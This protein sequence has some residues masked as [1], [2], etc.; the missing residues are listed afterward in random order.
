MKILHTSDWHIG[1]TLY[2]KKRY[3]EFFEFLNWLIRT[4]EQEKIELLL[5]AGDIF[6]TS[7][8]GNQAQALY[9]QFLCQAAASCCRHIVIIAGNHD[10]PSFL[11]AP[12]QLLQSLN[13]YV[14]AAVSEQIEDELIV[15]N[16]P[17]DNIPELIVCAVPF[18][19]DRDVR[20]VEAGE[21]IDD[22][23]LKLIEG[24]KKHYAKL[25]HLA[26]KKQDELYHVSNK[27]IPIIAMGHLFTAGGKT[28]DGDGVRELYVG[29]IAHVTS[30][31]FPDCIDYLALGH[32]HV[33]QKINQ[34]EFKRYSG[35][36][37]AMGFGEAGQVKSLCCVDINEKKEIKIS[38]IEVPKFQ[39]LEQI[40]G[41]WE[42]I[43]NRVSEIKLLKTAV[44]LEV[45]YNGEDVIPDIREKLEEIIIETEIEIL[46]IT[47]NRIIERVLHP[48]DDLRTLDDMNR[49]EVFEECL[50]AHQIPDEQRQELMY[51]YQ[52]TLILIDQD[53]SMID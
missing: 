33:P 6:D 18:L 20:I 48:M 21:S 25:C 35:S 15:L 23:E 30:A 19:R 39:N 34:S 7:T 43:F 10:S 44:W 46:R 3:S 2:G 22:K 31:I 27:K 9:Y 45:I 36:P 1:R 4:I 24:I 40:K 17:E 47:N 26:E 13:V 16:H 37:V 49:D 41:D 28:I 42:K 51:T 53:D 11:N 8:P 50:S 52:Q 14:V 5:V 38:L 32:L 29:S 12:K